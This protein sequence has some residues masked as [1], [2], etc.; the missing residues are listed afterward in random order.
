MI[1]F[2]ERLFRFSLFRRSILICCHII[3]KKKLLKFF[4]NKSVKKCI[5]SSWFSI[6]V[7]KSLFVWCPSIIQIFFWFSFLSMAFAITLQWQKD[8]MVGFNFLI[9]FCSFY[10]ACF[11]QTFN[12]LIIGLIEISNNSISITSKSSRFH[13]RFN[14]R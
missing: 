7:T 11:P 14:F 2:R 1:S 12:E 5:F 10:V 4:E 3:I 9:F 13:N 6:E 8:L